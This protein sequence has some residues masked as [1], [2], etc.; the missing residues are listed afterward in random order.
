MPLVGKTQKWISLL[1]YRPTCGYFLGARCEFSTNLPD[2]TTAWIAQSAVFLPDQTDAASCYIRKCSLFFST[3]DLA[4]ASFDSTATE[5]YL[6]LY[7]EMALSQDETETTLLDAL[8]EEL[9][10]FVEVPKLEGGQIAEPQ[11]YWSTEPIAKETALIPHGACKIRFKWEVEVREASW[12]KHHY[13]VAK[14]VQ[15]ECGFDPSTNAVAKALDLPLL[16]ACPKSSA[17]CPAVGTS[18]FHVAQSLD[19]G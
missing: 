9:H 6:V 14:S 10:V 4:N 15:E 3:R 12:G 7:W 2:I 13:D 1:D 11:I 8:P 5:T 16:E 17:S 19:G 18:Y